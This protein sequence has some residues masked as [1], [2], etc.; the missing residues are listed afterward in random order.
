MCIF[1]TQKFASDSDYIFF[2]HSAL[3]QLNTNCQKNVVMRKTTSSNL[4][5]DM[6]KQNFKE[7]VHQFIASNESSNFMNGI[8]D[9][10][11]F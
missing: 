10:L 3:E 1:C 8:K 11:S 2:A 4:T 5:A 9:K 6:L 7:T